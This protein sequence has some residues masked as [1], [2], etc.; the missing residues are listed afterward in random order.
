M[1]NAKGILEYLSRGKSVAKLKMRSPLPHSFKMLHLLGKF[2]LNH[3]EFCARNK[4][5]DVV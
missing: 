2:T 5:L 4:L 3:M 1:N